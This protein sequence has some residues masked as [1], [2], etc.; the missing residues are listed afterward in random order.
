[1]DGNTDEDENDDQEDG[2]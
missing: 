1:V 2:S